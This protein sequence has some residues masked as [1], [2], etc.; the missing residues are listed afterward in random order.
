MFLNV[1]NAA[2]TATEFSAA[3]PLAVANTKM[4]ETQAAVAASGENALIIYTEGNPEQPSIGSI[5][6][7]RVFD[8]QTNTL[9]PRVAAINPALS[10]DLLFNPAVIALDGTRY[11]VVFQQPVRSGV[12]SNL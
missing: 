5:L 10:G 6:Y 12:F 9:G 2:G 8:G 1:V 11:A 4:N 7:M 3:S